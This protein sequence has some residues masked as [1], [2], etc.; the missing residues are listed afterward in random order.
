[1]NESISQKYWFKNLDFEIKYKQGQPIENSDEYFV[2]TDKHRFNM[3]NIYQK[4]TDKEIYSFA[5]DMYKFYMSYQFNKKLTN[6]K[7][8]TTNKIKEQLNNI[9]INE[10]HEQFNNFY[11]FN[12]YSPWNK[13]ESDTYKFI[14]YDKTKFDILKIEFVK[15]N[16]ITNKTMYDNYLI[17][18]HFI[19]YVLN[20]IRK[21][22][23]SWNYQY[24]EVINRNI[25][26]SFKDFI[27][28]S[29]PKYIQKK[30]RDIGTYNN[31]VEEQLKKNDN[32][33]K[34]T[35][36]Q[37]DLFSFF[38]LTPDNLPRQE[39]NFPLNLV[40]KDLKDKASITS[41]L[42][43]NRGPYIYMGKLGVNDDGFDELTFNNETN[44]VY[45]NGA[46][47]FV[48]NDD[49]ELDFYKATPVEISNKNLKKY[50][51]F[52]TDGYKFET[53]TTSFSYKGGK[54]KK[55]TKPKVVKKKPVKVI[56]KKRQI[57]T[58][59]SKK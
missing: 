18:N 3:Q 41:F 19:N 21:A 2:K 10:N 1:M 44:K 23:N 31:M 36:R 42:D 14:V 28:A 16:R 27:P 22:K 15:L 52:E 37:L 25:K 12:I 50:E 20:N 49:W 30:I 9:L 46:G 55:P 57:K 39:G 11:I 29:D 35:N 48:I 53:A 26:I 34:I 58:K 32:N 54:S 5:E 17:E 56:N 38:K 59:Y 13:P 8:L 51:N 24:N 33:T 43:K 40:K 45:L 4:Y 7:Y 6:V 47:V